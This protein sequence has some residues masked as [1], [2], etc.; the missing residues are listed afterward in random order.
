MLWNNYLEKMQDSFY[1]HTDP[2]YYYKY[3]YQTRKDVPEK[4]QNLKYVKQFGDVIQGHIEPHRIHWEE[5]MTEFRYTGGYANFHLMRFSKGL[6]IDTFPTWDLYKDAPTNENI[7]DHFL[8]LSNDRYGQPKGIFKKQ[9]PYTLFPLQMTAVKD[10]KETLRYIVW[11]TKSKTYTIFKTHPCPGG[12]TNYEALWNFAKKHNAISEYTVLVDGYRSQE[13]VEGADRIVSVDS[14]LSFKG[15]L[16]D[17]PTCTLRI[18]TMMNDVIPCAPT[19]NSILDVKPVPHKDK[20]KWLNW[21]YHRVCIDFHE[22]D[23]ADKLLY[24]FRQYEN[25]GLTDYEVH[26]W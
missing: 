22:E 8:S 16:Y 19:D 1:D 17:K 18:H 21:F 14:G 23:Y 11:A 20:L 2:K 12:G 9:R 25:Q 3:W 7:Y 13:L 15:M 24:K 6:Y 4:L 26:K 5:K 10:F